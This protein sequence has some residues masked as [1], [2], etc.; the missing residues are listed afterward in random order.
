MV[1]ICIHLSGGGNGN[2]L[3]YS[4]L[5][6]SMDRGAPQAIV[7]E[8]QRVGIDWSDTHIGLLCVCVLI[9]DDLSRK[10]YHTVCLL[11]TQN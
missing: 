4:Y 11:K 7:Y 10:F 6:N 8:S 2:Q 5:E 1:C 3:Q 9:E